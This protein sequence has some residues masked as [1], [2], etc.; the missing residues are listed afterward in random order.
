M[1][2]MKFAKLEQLK[3]SDMISRAIQKARAEFQIT[4]L[5]EA[6]MI[7]GIA[8]QTAKKVAVPPPEASDKKTP[9]TAD[10]F[11]PEG[12]PGTIPAKEAELIKE[13]PENDNF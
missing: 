3:A 1:A 6:E 13:A 10:M 2:K 11:P 5:D 9:P 12:E 8:W 7:I 4:D